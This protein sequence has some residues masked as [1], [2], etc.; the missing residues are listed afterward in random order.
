MKFHSM[1][2]HRGLR[3]SGSRNGVSGSR[4]SFQ[5][6]QAH[7][8]RANI[9]QALLGNHFAIQNQWAWRFQISIWL[10]T[11]R[12]ITR[13]YRSSHVFHQNF[14]RITGGTFPAWGHVHILFR[15][16][17]RGVKWDDLKA[18]VRWV[19]T[20]QAFTIRQPKLRSLAPY[21]TKWSL[22]RDLESQKVEDENR[23]ASGPT[24]NGSFVSFYLDVSILQEKAHSSFRMS[25][26]AISTS[27]NPCGKCLPK[28]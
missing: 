7:L 8:F 9:A 6:Y 14:G 19:V 11:S 3:V 17:H 16:F 20:L 24:I 2:H 4:V 26:L 13:F 23:I 1:K 21:K 5:T 15:G 28:H 12:L 10:Q 18:R 27:E 22:W 25:Q